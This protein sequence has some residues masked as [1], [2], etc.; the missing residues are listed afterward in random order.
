MLEINP[1]VRKEALE[2]RTYQL[3]VAGEAVKR[4]TLVVLP[5]ALGKTVIA[6]LVAS[7]FLYWYSGNK[8][9]VMAP[10]RPLVLQHR[11]TFFRILRL[12]PQDVQV[13]TGKR[14]PEYRLHVW[15]GPARL[16]FAT[17]Q[18]VH[19]DHK[20]GLR[21]SDFS[22]LI[23]DECHRARKNYAYTKVAEAYH[24]ESPHPIILGLTAS[25]GADR[26]KI[27]EI[28][29]ALYVE[30][31][32]ARTEEDPDVK[33]YVSPIAV[34]WKFLRLP[35]S[36]QNLKKV[37]RDMLDERLR[38]L[39]SMGAIKK[40]PRY[41]FR[42]D[43]LK[44]GEELRYRIGETP[45]DEERSRFFGVLIVQ[46]SALTLYHA[47]ELLESQGAHSL[48]CFLKRVETGEK[49]SHRSIAKELAS[50]GVYRL[51]DSLEE[52]PKL[53]ALREVLTTQLSKNP[54][55]N[56]IVFTQYRDTSS[57]LSERLSEM[58]IS[59][60]RFIGQTDKKGDEGLTQE[61]QAKLLERF[62]KGEFKVL[63]AT[64]IA[65]EGLDV[66]SVDLIVFYE[67]VPS[68]IRYIQRRGRTGRKRFGRVVILAAEDT[69][70]MTYLRRS[71]KMAERMK[72]M[73]R[74]LNLEL[75]PILR[76]GSLEKR[77]MPEDLILEAEKYVPG[78]EE[79]GEEPPSEVGK[80]WEE[81][82]LGEF[83]REV[84]KASKRILERILRTPGIS[85]AELTNELMADGLDHG[86]AKAAVK[87]LKDENQVVVLGEKVF[88]YGAEMAKKGSRPTHVFEVERILPGKAVLF[89]DEKW[90]A[91]LLPED[92]VGPRHLLRKGTKFRAVSELYRLNG[93][94]HARIYGVE[95]IE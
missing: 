45:V 90:R 68:E 7:H 75:K 64:S 29:S 24:R 5:T 81:K 11:D 54:S 60:A 58:G 35:E 73:V 37:L 71:R 92:Y 33:P 36:Y 84:R 67:P 93:K 39:C 78:I 12:R 62:R 80:V 89:V 30:H 21:L 79:G 53:S 82:N 87:R 22:L 38:K 20:L 57:Y 16:Y 25:P 70:D 94:F 86:M 66:P 32:E 17:P 42:S 51:L 69:I 72:T 44:L 46:S 83:S 59:C 76:T 13:L 40:D 14:P 8:V 48:R 52:H 3:K 56:A 41:I 34:E 65:E 95:S 31:V 47:L 28:C 26:K 63:V 91:V 6:A 10:T 74:G 43:L 4:N 9:L 77:P 61:E 2:E 55:S 85:L 23:F 49:L 50:K 18:V 15:N 1:L 27:K 19:N 88:P